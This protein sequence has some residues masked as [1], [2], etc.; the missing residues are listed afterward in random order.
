[1]RKRQLSAVLLLVFGL[2]FFNSVYSAHVIAQPVTYTV[3]KG[4]TLW[5]I[6]DKF[7]GD[8]TLWPELWEMN[9]FITNP[10]LL[11]PGDVITLL[12]DLPVKKH[13]SV[14]KPLSIL[15]E[16]AV[17]VSGLT[18]VNSTGFF[19]T[20]PFKPFGRIY[21]D[22]TGRVILHSSDIIY[23]SLNKGNEIA[24]GDLLT[25]SRTSSLIDD[26]LTEED[27]GYVVSF[28]GK[29]IITG[30]VKG[31]IYKAEIIKTYEAVRVGDSVIP[32]EPMSPCVK[33]RAVENKL[34]A[35][36]MA[37]K[38]LRETIGQFSVVYL[39]CG[40]TKGVRRGNLFEVITE[41]KVKSPHESIRTDVNLG[42]LLVLLA[43]SDSATCVVIDSRKD[44]A[45]G[46]SVKGLDREKA[47]P[48][49]LKLP[50]CPE[51]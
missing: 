35:H 15:P 3:K 13:V 51:K 34:I 40:I 48:I 50:L 45:N 2:F 12:K 7:Y 23:I 31:N 42:Y 38:G 27:A 49:L 30:H 1:L 8:S 5:N 36:I 24:Q 6:C 25:I 26:P 37:T 29:V 20:R 44:F 14:E 9:P 43:R 41:S 16:R 28:L 22:D 10:N 17:D 46:A 11:A 33:P 4:D 47:K 21:S 32:Y 39:N 18:D 19:T